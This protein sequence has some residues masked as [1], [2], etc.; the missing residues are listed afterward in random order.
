ME[1]VS[2]IYPDRNKQ[3]IQCASNSLTETQ[4]KYAQIEKAYMLSF[5]A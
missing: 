4:K 1:I 5:L 2:H 3:I